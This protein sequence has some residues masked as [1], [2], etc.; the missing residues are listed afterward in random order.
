MEIY[1]VISK[2]VQLV[3]VYT[4]MFS[5]CTVGQTNTCKI[6]SSPVM[7]RDQI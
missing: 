6:P 1:T 5:L 2:Y 7:R 3:T 4:V